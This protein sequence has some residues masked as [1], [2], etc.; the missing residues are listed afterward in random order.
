MSFVRIVLA[1]A[2]ALSPIPAS[3]T[4]PAK[5]PDK[6]DRTVV[7]SDDEAAVALAKPAWES[8]DWVEVRRVLEPL[9]SSRER[10]SDPRVR[11]TALLYLAD[12][13]ISDTTLDPTARRGLAGTYIQ[14]LL[15]DDPSW[16]MPPD[17]YS[18]ELY[19][20][21]LEIQEERT[22]K[23]D[24]NCQAELTACKSDV[25]TEN[26]RYRELQAKYDKLQRDYAEQEIEVR[27]QISRSRFFAAIPF[28]VGHFYNGA[29]GGPRAK[30]VNRALGA[31][32]LSAELAFGGAGLGLLLYRVI[33]D[34]CRRS[35]GFQAGSLQCTGENDQPIKQRRR[36]EEVMGWFF[37]GSVALD[38][39]LAQ[40]R[41]RPVET[42]RVQ[43]IKRRELE[44]G[45]PIAPDDTP[46]RRPA[47]P[48][49]KVRPTGAMIPGGAGLGVSVRF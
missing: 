2:I 13:T 28:G 43:R 38:I 35:K 20:L 11:E 23:I 22:R 19:N 26:E 25:A 41:F 40:I 44:S 29:V 7:P 49:A 10:L 6:N 4:G 12:A 48:R 3:A 36:A 46:Q 39:V 30:K 27:D 45:E 24:A 16:R 37:I 33:A 15:D 34:G 32:F 31:T 42:V 5:L 17:I 8:G 21:F 47:R 1:A 9:A 18:P 14:R